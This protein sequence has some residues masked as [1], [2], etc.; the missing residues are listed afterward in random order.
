MRLGGERAC[1]WTVSISL[2]CAL[3]VVAR[4][5]SA[6]EPRHGRR[7]LPRPSGSTT[8]GGPDR[9]QA[10]SNH[11]SVVQWQPSLS[12][13]LL[14][15]GRR[16]HVRGSARRFVPVRRG[17]LRVP[18][19]QTSGRE[20]NSRRRYRSA[21]VRFLQLVGPRMQIGRT[22]AGRGRRG[23]A[24]GDHRAWGAKTHAALRNCRRG[25]ARVQGSADGRAS[26]GQ[27]KFWPCPNS[28]VI[29]SERTGLVWLIRSRG[30]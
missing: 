16:R 4:V 1:V 12:L 22:A 17:N 26:D 8:P 18:E 20:R 19:R 13:D 3:G 27:Q 25:V 11:R 10:S 24:L 6:T 5:P 21:K 30:A 28:N 9:S 29:R 14:E 23:L 2:R 15:R 7:L